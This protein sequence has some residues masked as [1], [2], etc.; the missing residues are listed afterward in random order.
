MPAKS[1]EEFEAIRTSCRSIMRKGSDPFTFFWNLLFSVS[2]SI[3][4]LPAD[5]G[6]KKTT[7]RERLE[8]KGYTMLPGPTFSMHVKLME[9]IPRNFGG[10]SSP[11]YVWDT[12]L[13]DNATGKIFAGGAG[14][15]RLESSLK[16]M[17]KP[18]RWQFRDLNGDGFMDYRY[19]KGEVGKPFWWAWVWQPRGKYGRFSLSPK[20]GGNR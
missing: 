11:L 15:G 4:A 18:I 14:G 12:A 1:V 3:V 9:T 17:D 19:D 5:A 10:K 7:S 20:Y 6:V 13:T 16:D 2:L 8:A